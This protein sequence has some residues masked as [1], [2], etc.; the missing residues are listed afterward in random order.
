V[1]ALLYPAAFRITDYLQNIVPA[2]QVTSS[3]APQAD[4]VNI[5]GILSEVGKQV[6]LNST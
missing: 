6:L 1:L 3:A 4:G 5:A 2:S